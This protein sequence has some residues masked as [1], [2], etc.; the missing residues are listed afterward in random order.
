MK[1]LVLFFFV[2][3]VSSSIFSQEYKI[4]FSGT[5]SS[6]TVSSIFVENLT[7][8]KSVTLD[9]NETLHLAA[10]ITGINDVDEVEEKLIVSPNPIVD[11]G[12]VTFFA[13]NE[14]LVS[15]EILES[16]GVLVFQKSYYLYPG[17]NSLKISE[18]GNGIFILN[19]SSKTYSYSGKI[20][21]IKRNHIWV[22]APV[23]ESL[24][25]GTT[26]I[27]KL[28]S[29]SAE[30]YLIF[31][32][33]DILKITGKSGDYSTIVGDSPVADKTITFN[34]MPCVD[35][36]GNNYP[37]VQIGN[38]VWM[39]ENLRTTKLNDG[40]EIP[41]IPKDSEWGALTTP[42]YCWANNDATNK[43]PYGGLYNWFAVN[44]GKLAPKGWHVPTDKEW[45]DLIV[46]LG[47]D[48]LGLGGWVVC[49][50]QETGNL[51]RDQYAFNQFSAT[52]ETG[53]S[54]VPNGMRSGESG[55]PGFFSGFKNY[56]YYW[57]S[58]NGGSTPDAEGAK[59]RYI[60]NDISI[61]V[62]LKKSGM[63]VRCIKD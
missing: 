20:L 55:N 21:S 61:M 54:M 40:A 51:H 59:C 56:G 17:T 11:E 3:L 49:K 4:S 34:F 46:F 5:G 25:L 36:D 14:G 50:L 37:V 7:Q 29:V 13:K 57:T 48:P 63:G 31:K 38:Q 26:V 9:G 30:K 18:L 22:N 8:N 52:N 44:T 58:I 2:M 28:K 27:Q 35:G 53:F 33:G 1:K 6:S 45:N 42:G 19:I 62:M 10:T 43:S 32:K 47:G 15:V 23:V 60:S 39:G 24:G 12:V 16:S 41:N